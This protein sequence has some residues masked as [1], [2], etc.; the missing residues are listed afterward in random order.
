MSPTTHTVMID[1]SGGF[2]QSLE[3]DAAIETY[4]IP[5]LV[6]F[7]SFPVIQHPT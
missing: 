4:V 3:P 1:M 2:L 5:R 7:T 6:P